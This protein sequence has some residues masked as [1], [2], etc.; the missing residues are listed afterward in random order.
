MPAYVQRAFSVFTLIK[1]L[2]RWMMKMLAKS[3]HRIPT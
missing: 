1:K 2:T 3:A